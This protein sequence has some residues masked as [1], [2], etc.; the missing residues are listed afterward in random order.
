M[1]D[2]LL[3]YQPIVDFK[4]RINE[5]CLKVQKY[6]NFSPLKMDQKP[7]P[8]PKGPQAQDSQHSLIKGYHCPEKSAFFRESGS[9]IGTPY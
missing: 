4:T 1:I 3:S 6:G 8:N 7:P 5:I 2:L 9:L